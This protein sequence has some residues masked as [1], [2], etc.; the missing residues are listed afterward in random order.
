[1][2]SGFRATGFSGQTPSRSI[3][4]ASRYRCG[5]TLQNRT[6]HPSAI[7]DYPLCYRATYGDRCSENARRTLPKMRAQSHHDPS[8]LSVPEP[9]LDQSVAT[10]RPVSENTRPNSAP[11]RESPRKSCFRAFTD[12]CGADFRNPLTAVRALSTHTSVSIAAQSVGTH[13]F[14]RKASW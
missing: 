11:W 9:A 14:G 2:L 4:I 13:I 1:M 8:G 6:G 7:L 10:W 3:D 5:S 12:D